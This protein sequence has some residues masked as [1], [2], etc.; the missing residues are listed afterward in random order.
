MK[1]A[2][3]TQSG[4]IYFITS[5]IL[6]FI[7][8]I[9][10]EI[11]ITIC[12]MGLFLYIVIAFI[13]LLVNG[14][15]WK[16][17]RLSVNVKENR[18]VEILPLEKK[19][20]PVLLPCFIP[21][22]IFKLF[23]EIT[24]TKSKHITI[25]IKLNKTKTIFL[26]N[27]NERGVFFNKTEY[28][29]LKD[30]AGFVSA[31]FFY[32]KKSINKIVYVPSYGISDEIKIPH[33]FV[34]YADSLLNFKRNDELYDMRRYVAGDD[35]RKINWKVYAHTNQL[36]IMQGDFTPPPN[37]FLTIIFQTPIVDKI[38]EFSQTV[39]E[40]FVHRTVSIL[41]NLYL[42]NKSF[43][44]ILFDQNQ[45]Q[46]KMQTVFCDD[47]NGVEKIKSFFSIPQLNTYL[48]K[49]TGQIVYNDVNQDENSIL[50]FITPMLHSAIDEITVLPDLNPD[51]SAV[52]LYN[53]ENII[54][55]PDT[56]I[57]A[58][59]APQKLKRIIRRL[60]FT[61]I[62]ENKRLKYIMRL[63][64]KAN[65]LKSEIQKRGVYACTV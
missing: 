32:E 12:A 42:L 55:L 19:S 26:I 29:E 3:L 38:T 58:H 65:I 4:L 51:K 8:L 11:F 47:K 7:G 24:N 9:R 22:Y 1:T 10:G 6:L 54:P 5:V 21:H 45:R 36:A 62:K 52:Y 13:L 18:T 17:L 2:G 49:Q 35:I 64:K 15:F 50:Y 28:L 59:N 20:L 31:K 25:N 46:L 63:N 16:N 43:K 61:T 41:I 57:R 60:L 14:L 39:F 37:D 53:Y 44:I 30:I 40:Y 33:F 27:E 56:E 34:N 23:T 48:N